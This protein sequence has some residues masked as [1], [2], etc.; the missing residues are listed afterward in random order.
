MADLDPGPATS[1][2]SSNFDDL[3]MAKYDNSGNYQWGK[4]IS[5]PDG[6]CG[7]SMC[8]DAQGNV[9]LAGY[10]QTLTDM[11]PGPATATIT[12]FPSTINVQ[13]G[14]IAKYDNAGNYV[15]AKA[16]QTPSY[17]SID[18]IRLDASGSLIVAGSFR[19]TLDVDPGPG[20]VKLG[21]QGYIDLFVA[22]YS[23]AGNYLWALD[24]GGSA[25]SINYSSGYRNVG[26]DATG[27]VYVAGTYSGTVD[28]DPGPSTQH[29]SS[30]GTLFNLYL[31]RYSGISTSLQALPASNHKLGFYPNPCKN[32]G[33]L[34]LELK[35][36]VHAQ[37]TL[38]DASGRV[39]E[40]LEEAQLSAGNH[41]YELKLKEQGVYFVRT[42]LEG[43]SETKKIVVVE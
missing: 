6:E 15:W 16:I 10:F 37:I 29:L 11:D 5:T 13:N 3:F 38:Y 23:N 22:K 24:I 30:N 12:T 40:L 19:D 28:F 20:V 25:G 42:V 43:V 4:I 26:I 2:F 9:Y 36:S 33:W 39:M 27:N 8:L 21:V 14:F 17:S 7:R 32:Q 1:T 41:R 31:A 35:T 18:C 34:F